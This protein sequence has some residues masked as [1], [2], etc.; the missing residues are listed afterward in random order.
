MMEECRL[1]LLAIRI[2]KSGANRR[3]G[4]RA[5]AKA[6]CRTKAPVACDFPAAAH[7]MIVQRCSN[8][9][10][11]KVVSADPPLRGWGPL[12]PLDLRRR[13]EGFDRRRKRRKT[14]PTV[15]CVT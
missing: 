6:T 4:D 8:T 5:N 7:G 11:L 14:K 15:K 12:P 2:R 3:R 10:K 1:R 13:A 9:P